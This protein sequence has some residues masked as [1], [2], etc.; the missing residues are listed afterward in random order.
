[1]KEK[2]QLP[3]DFK[4]WTMIPIYLVLIGIVFYFG[5]VLGARWAWMIGSLLVGILTGLPAAKWEMAAIGES[6]DE[7]LHGPLVGFR[8]AYFKKEGARRRSFY[9]L[10]MSFLIPVI[11]FLLSYNFYWYRYLSESEI[12]ESLYLMVRWNGWYWF[13]YVFGMSFS[14]TCLPRLIAAESFKNDKIPYPRGV[15][16]AK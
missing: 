15:K 9:F 2:I 7:I 13:P 8:L 16:D 1:M 10:I 14:S 5:S 3:L 6:W 11:Y 12:R 4:L